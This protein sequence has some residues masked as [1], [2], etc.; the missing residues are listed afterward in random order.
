MYIKLVFFCATILLTIRE[1]T[2]VEIKTSPKNQYLETSI[3]NINHLHHRLFYNLFV[4]SLSVTKL[5]PWETS[6]PINIVADFPVTEELYFANTSMNYLPQFYSLPRLKKLAIVS[7]NI[8]T[9][10]NDTLPKLSVERLYF[11]RNEIYTVEDNSFGKYVKVLHMDCNNL[12]QLS[13]DWFTNPQK[14][15]RLHL[16]GNKIKYLQ[17]N[18]LKDFVNLDGIDLSYN[19]LTTIGDG[20]FSGSEQYSLLSISNNNLVELK[21]TIFSSNITKI[22]LFMI[23]Y[24]R[25]TFLNQAL[26]DKLAINHTEI[27]G[28]PWQCPCYMNIEKWLTKNH[29][30]L[31]PFRYFVYPRN[32]PKCIYALSYSKH[33]IEIVESEFYYSYSKALLYKR[34][35]ISECNMSDGVMKYIYNYF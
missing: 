12:E 10:T 8:S 6:R 14:L 22:N 9:I 26:L 25:L 3:L 18:A 24:N 2:I 32:E 28:N 16:L 19:E 13:S 35:H 5:A 30:E 7:N 17:E 33:C 34:N 4:Y 23:D 21:P 1:C 15:E 11:M 31:S 20:A 27:R 29:V